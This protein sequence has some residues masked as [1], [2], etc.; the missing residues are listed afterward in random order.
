MVVRTHPQISSPVIVGYQGTAQFCTHSIGEMTSSAAHNLFLDTD[1]RTGT[2]ASVSLPHPSPPHHPL[3]NQSNARRKRLPRSPSPPPSPRDP[4]SRPRHTLYLF[5]RDN[6]N[7]YGLSNRR[8]QIG[9][10]V[11]PVIRG[12]RVLN[13]WTCRARDTCCRTVFSADIYHGRASI[14]VCCGDECHD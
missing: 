13:R 6:R 7:L 2:S 1:F 5:S 11:C 12:C 14:D 8:I 10:P 4:R 9:T 3:T